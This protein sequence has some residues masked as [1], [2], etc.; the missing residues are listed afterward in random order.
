[1]KKL[2]IPIIFIILLCITLAN[3]N[4][5]LL[6]CYPDGCEADVMEEC[7]YYCFNRGGCEGAHAA[8]G[9]CVGDFCQS[10]WYM[11]CV[12]GSGFGKC[13]CEGDSPQC[14]S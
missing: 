14:Q 12:E 6:A 8:H 4:L 9:W 1:M 5:T 10:V 7:E 13:Y 2:L 11:F 3:L